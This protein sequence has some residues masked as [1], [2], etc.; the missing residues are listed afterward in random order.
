MRAGKVKESRGPWGEP[1]MLV[2]ETPKRRLGVG[3]AVR[4]DVGEGEREFRLEGLAWEEGV[5][6]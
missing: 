2:A 1:K 5:V 3:E 4:L 6:V